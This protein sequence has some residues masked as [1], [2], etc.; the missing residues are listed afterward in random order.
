M[1]DS[2]YICEHGGIGIIKMMTFF[3]LLFFHSIR[4]SILFV[5]NII[6]LG[7]KQTTNDSISLTLLE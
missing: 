5:C 7:I 1:A 2:I 4:I 3:F 6:I